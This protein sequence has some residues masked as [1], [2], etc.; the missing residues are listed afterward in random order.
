MRRTPGLLALLAAVAATVLSLR[1]DA[2]PHRSG[3]TDRFDV[4]VLPGRE[5]IVVAASI[6]GLGRLDDARAEAILFGS[7]GEP[8]QRREVPRFEEPVAA[9]S[10]D[11]HGLAAGTYRV[12][13]RLAA[14][15]RTLFE[16]EWSIPIEPRPE[17]LGNTIG[18]L[19]RDEVPEPWTPVTAGAGVVGVWNRE[20]RMADALL[21]SGIVSAGAELL[22]R[23]IAL[24]ADV[25]GT[26][27]SSG[28][29]RSRVT[30]GSASRV[31]LEAT[32]TLGELSVT[33]RTFVE[34]DGFAW[35]R[36]TLTPPR[37]TRVAGL[38]LEIPLRAERATL[39]NSDRQDLRGTGR[40]GAAFATR[41]D[42]VRQRVIS[43]WI[44]DEA[45]GFHFCAASDRGWRL[46]RPDAAI[47][48]ERRGGEVVMRI[49]FI[50]RAVALTAPL[51][52]EFGFAATPVRPRP[53]GARAWRFGNGDDPGARLA[54]GA[55]QT[56]SGPRG[57][58]LAYG[59]AYWSRF[60]R[61]R[62]PEP[63]PDALARLEALRAQA[64][65]PVLDASLGWT[66]PLGPEY[67][68]FR[69][70]WH[71]A[72]FLWPDLE[73]M[74]PVRDWL[75]YPASASAA[76]FADWQLF[77]LRRLIGE[78]RLRAIYFDMS[79][80]TLNGRFASGSGFQDPQRGWPPLAGYLPAGY[81]PARPGRRL[82]DVVG[83]YHPETELLA[84]RELFKRFY[85]VAKR[86]DPR[87]L[88]LLHASGD[89]LPGIQSFVDAVLDGEQL[90][91]AMRSASYEQ[92]LPLDVFR[93]AFMGWNYGPAAV[94][95]PEFEASA[96][97]LGQDP[98]FWSTP[99]AHARI[100][101]LLG[102]ILVHDG[103]IVPAFSAPEPYELVRQAEDALGGWDD[104][105]EFL[106]YWD[107]RL[108]VRLEPARAD[109]VASVFRRPA[110]AGGA[111]GRTL[112]VAF[113]DTDRQA[114]TTL[115]IDV[116]VAS[117]SVTR[118]R[119]LLRGD[120]FP[121]RREAGGLVA[122]VGLPARDFRMLVLE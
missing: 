109:V 104:S 93:A 26:R 107:P 52:L 102:L 99:A 21:P 90:R 83:R 74:D 114:A 106:P 12:A 45:R 101:H 92:A 46:S 122:G 54:P 2:Y 23:P 11:S 25:A 50:D 14:G 117:A 75:E 47:G 85:V 10:F 39:Y 119:D 5:Q 16:H 87:F 29:A 19:G 27:R 96:Q 37:P 78:L 111:G 110:G 97:A 66:F 84:T 43:A 4:A 80:P 36:L 88:I 7:A 69:D 77:A 31:E 91:G 34:F 86:H 20:Y 33:T 60:P 59:V 55:G 68:A 3:S 81:G 67:R 120:S 100:R 64:I 40:T 118:L 41:Y 72:P 48:Y 115:R 13:A 95:L 15:P 112:V 98:R 121:V 30:L 62:Y 49:R 35:V 70:E 53:A 82:I 6:E 32:G 24:V 108:P 116:T 22:S 8:L 61:S 56:R 63:A 51:E 94:F 9:M 38:S 1:G 18:K 113:N 42:P 79:A 103:Q 76:S 89:A 28:T 105:L 57:T 58:N 44:G 73:R 17:W 71:P 65:E